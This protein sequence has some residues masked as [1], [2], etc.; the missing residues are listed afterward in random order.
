MAYEYRGGNIGSGPPVKDKCKA[1]VSEKGKYSS[2]HQHQCDKKPW[3]D[4]WCKIHH[5]YSEKTR[6][7]ASNKRY[8]ERLKTLEYIRN[9]PLHE[10]KEKI[11]QLEARVKLLETAIHEALNASDLK[12]ARVPLCGAMMKSL[13]ITDEDREWAKKVLS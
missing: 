8:E 7:E 2:F 6:R 5:P 4:G 13:P 11:T 3:K 10:A 1:S 12:T 9:A